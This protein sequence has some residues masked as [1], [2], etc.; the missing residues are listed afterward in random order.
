MTE[1]NHKTKK[2]T[3][4]IKMFQHFAIKFRFTT[5]LEVVLAFFLQCGCSSTTKNEKEHISVYYDQ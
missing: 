5:W 3:D 4:K 2:M 1:K